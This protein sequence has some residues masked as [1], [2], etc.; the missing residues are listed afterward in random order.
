MAVFE[1]SASHAIL[2]FLEEGRRGGGGGGRGGKGWKGVSPLKVGG[3]ADVTRQ[4]PV[5]RS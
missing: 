4:L 1:S 5:L 2:V 3:K